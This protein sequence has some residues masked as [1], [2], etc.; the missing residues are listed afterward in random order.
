METI[1]EV[2]DEIA[3]HVYY[4][5]QENTELA[6]KEIIIDYAEQKVKERDEQWKSLILPIVT[7]YSLFTLLRPE[8]YKDRIELQLPKLKFD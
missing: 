2:M 4:G 6:V 1:E 7:D 5:E 3:N 8:I